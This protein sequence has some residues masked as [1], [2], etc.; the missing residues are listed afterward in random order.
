MSQFQQHALVLAQ[1][2]TS[3]GWLD[4]FRA[5]ATNQWTKTLWPTKKTEAW[6]YTPLNNLQKNTDLTWAKNDSFFQSMFQSI[7]DL[8]AVDAI[9]LVFVNGIFDTKASSELPTEVVRFSQASPD[10]QKIIKQHLGSVIEGDK[11]LFSGLNNAWLDEGVLI[12]LKAGQ[13]LSKPVYLVQVSQGTVSYAINH[14]LL[15][16][17]EQNSRAEIIEHFISASEQQ[18]HFVN[19]VTEIVLQ[20]NAC[21]HHYNLHLEDEQQQHI[22]AVH[23]NLGR[24]SQLRAFT[25]ALGSQ[26]TRIDYQCHHRG[27]GAELDLQGMYLPRNEQLVDY[28]TNIQHWVPHCTSNEIFRG[29]ISDQ[30]KAV[31]NGRIHIHP[32][33]QKTLAE[34]SNKNLLTSN[35]A[36]INTKPELEIYADDVKCAHGATVS[37]L[38]A[39][40]LYYLQSRGVSRADAQVMMSFGFI[41]ELLQAVKQEAVRQ[42]LSPRLAKLFGRDQALDW[43]E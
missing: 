16:V 43:V 8:I 24:S 15:V 30:A 20:D 36:E 6:M 13:E 11:H 18:S 38:N 14:R 40:A 23:V 26:L 29:I 22:G 28:H 1:H 32:Q 2:Q 4:E 19:A 41:N 12:H 17:L 33:A 9:R 25:L 7:N 31:F 27:Q 3:L 35:K 37:Q 21:L 42:Y 10:Q 39:N 34:L 5:Q